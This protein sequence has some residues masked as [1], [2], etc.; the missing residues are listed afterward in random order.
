MLNQQAEKEKKNKKKLINLNV[1]CKYLRDARTLKIIYYWC[2]IKCQS[3][4]QSNQ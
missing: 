2:K 1:A 4:D 3:V